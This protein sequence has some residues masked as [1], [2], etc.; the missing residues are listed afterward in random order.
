[1]TETDI[2]EA[3]ALLILANYGGY[4]NLR[5]YGVITNHPELEG[6]VKAIKSEYHLFHQHDYSRIY[7]VSNDGTGMPPIRKA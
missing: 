5:V 6:Q 4:G 3:D 2:N 1:M 7:A